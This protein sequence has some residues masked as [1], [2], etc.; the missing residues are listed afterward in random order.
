MRKKLNKKRGKRF[1]WRRL[2]KYIFRTVAKLKTK[3]CF[4]L[5]VNF[6]DFSEVSLRGYVHVD[7]YRLFISS[8]QNDFRYSKCIYNRQ[9]KLWEKIK[10]LNLKDEN[11]CWEEITARLPRGGKLEEGHLG[12]IRIM[13]S[14]HLTSPIFFAPCCTGR[15][16]QQELMFLF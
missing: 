9:I 8:K 4:P 11:T 3:S 1:L 7:G 15:R 10:R 16:T 5:N 13:F 2:V 14:F 12:T 6:N